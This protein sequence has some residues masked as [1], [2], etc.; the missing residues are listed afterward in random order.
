ML[1]IVYIEYIVIVHIEVKTRSH[2]KAFLSM[3]S[4]LQSTE[5]NGDKI[6]TFEVHKNIEQRSNV[7]QLLIKCRDC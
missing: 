7:Q 6:M 2:L 4:V 3:E 5:N 1:I